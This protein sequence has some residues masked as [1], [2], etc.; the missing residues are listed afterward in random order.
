MSLTLDMVTKRQALAEVIEETLND[1]LIDEGD[2]N[3]FRVVQRF[4]V[5]VLRSDANKVDRDLIMGNPI[6]YVRVAWMGNEDPVPQDSNAFG[7]TVQPRHEFA[8]FIWFEYEDADTYQGSSQRVW[9]RLM[10]GVSPTGLLPLLRENG[11][12][13]DDNGNLAYLYDPTDVI[14]PDAPIHM[15]DEDF[16]HFAQ[17][18]ITV[19]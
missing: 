11:G 9:D 3:L 13:E 17:F 6:R 8:V 1:V 14:V 19:K 10:E 7:A 4:Q 5:K 15:G 12:L 18:F 2:P 16:V